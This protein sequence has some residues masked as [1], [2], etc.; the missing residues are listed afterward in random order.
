MAQTPE[1]I[2]SL[3]NMLKEIYLILT[4]SIPVI[5]FESRKFSLNKKGLRF[6]G[7]QTVNYEPVIFLRL[8]SVH[9]Q[10]IADSPSMYPAPPPSCRLGHYG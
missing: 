9:E 5:R 3:D 7:G 10:R 6:M 2:G 8:Y 1:S 4:L